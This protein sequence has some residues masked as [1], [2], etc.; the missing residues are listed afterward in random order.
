MKKTRFIAIL[1]GIAM[2]ASSNA[3]WAVATDASA[4]SVY[5]VRRSLSEYHPAV[6]DTDQSKIEAGDSIVGT[7]TVYQGGYL[8]LEWTGEDT[9]IG[10][11]I[12]DYTLLDTADD[13]NPK[14]PYAVNPISE[15][16]CCLEEMAAYQENCR[17]V[18]PDTFETES[19]YIVTGTDDLEFV[20]ALMEDS[21]V[22]LCGKLYYSTTSPLYYDSD[23]D[24]IFGLDVLCDL[25]YSLEMF[26]LQSGCWMN[27]DIDFNGKVNADDSNIVLLD[28]LISM[29][30]GTPIS[31]TTLAMEDITGNGKVDADDANIILM[32][33]LDSLMSQN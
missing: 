1:I 32:M 23:T 27:G 14:I 9:P 21:R 25:D 26:P 29:V 20:A 6:A 30:Y 33:Y 17:Y 4:P 10:A 15:M 5:D 12:G 28:Y 7:Y 3:Y 22:R 8:A 19:L 18:K 13:L 24:E 2:M 11:K 31:S 16:E